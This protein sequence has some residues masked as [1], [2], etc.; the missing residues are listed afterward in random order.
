MSSKYVFD[1]LPLSPLIPLFFPAV[2]KSGHGGPPINPI[3]LSFLSFSI[4]TSSALARIHL[5]LLPL[6]RKWQ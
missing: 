4:R 6:T 2:E 1:N 5:A 3:M